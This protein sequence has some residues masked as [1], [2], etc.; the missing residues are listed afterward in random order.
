MLQFYTERRGGG[1][2]TLTGV[3][4]VFHPRPHF[5]E[6]KLRRIVILAKA[7]IQK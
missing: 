4:F 1:T 5:R 3:F 2:I 7:G 6:G